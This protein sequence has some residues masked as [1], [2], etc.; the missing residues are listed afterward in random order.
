MLSNAHVNRGMMTRIAAVGFAIWLGA[1]IVLRLA[2]QFV[3][4]DSGGPNNMLLLLVSVPTMIAV[5]RAVLSGPALLRRSLDARLG[6]ATVAYPVADTAR[7]DVR[8]QVFYDRTMTPT[9]DSTLAAL[10]AHGLLRPP[11]S[12]NVMT[13]IADSLIT[14]LRTLPDVSFVRAEP[15]VCAITNGARAPRWR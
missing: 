4:R 11:K 10:G 14:R 9:D 13:T 2:G 8:V 6:I 5:A 15:L 1:T 3:F 12:R 7:R